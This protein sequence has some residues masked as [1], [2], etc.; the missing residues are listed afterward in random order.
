MTLTEFLLARIAED[1]EEIGAEIFGHDDSAGPNGIGWA[2]VG[3]INEVLLSSH[4]RALAECEAKRRIVALHRE[5]VDEDAG[6][7]RFSTG[8]TECGGEGFGETV[9]WPCPTILYL[10]AIYADHP[11]YREEWRP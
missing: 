7:N 1:E 6:G 2:E 5:A 11:D 4:R 9:P 10:A 8:C 3:A